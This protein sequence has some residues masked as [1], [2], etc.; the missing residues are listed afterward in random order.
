MNAG[1]VLTYTVRIKNTFTASREAEIRDHIPDRTAYVNGSA[2]NGGVFANGVLNWKFTL[3]GGEEKTVSFRVTVLDAAKDTV[4][5]NRADAVINQM[6]FKTNEVENPVLPDPVKRVENEEGED[7]DGDLVPADRNVIYYITVKNP[8][9]KAQD[10]TISDA[11]DEGQTAAPSSISD[12][13]KLNGQTITWKIR[14][15]A[16]ESYTVSF[17]AMP[18]GLELTI[19]NKAAVTADSAVSETN[20]ASALS[21]SL[22]PI[23]FLENL[24]HHSHNIYSFFLKLFSIVFIL[25]L[26]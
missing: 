10:F 13:G 14:V 11:V 9:H 26:F 24:S 20:A 15:P 6:E 1:D 5:T 16:G 2:D 23:I 3:K 18:K 4:I 7:C 21:D 19:P 8:G 12:Q 25:Y 22:Y 17:A